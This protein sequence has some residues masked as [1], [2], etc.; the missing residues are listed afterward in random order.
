[1]LLICGLFIIF[2]GVITFTVVPSPS[3]PNEFD[4]NAYKSPLSY[5][6]WKKKFKRKFRL[7]FFCLNISLWGL[8]WTKIKIWWWWKW[9]IKNVVNWL[10][11]IL[12]NIFLLLLKFIMFF[13]FSFMFLIIPSKKKLWDEK[14]DVDPNNIQIFLYFFFSF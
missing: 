14:D 2:F 3:W 12:T 13:L 8:K 9:Y 11:S 10:W 1:M 5:L 7:Y 6:K 4:P